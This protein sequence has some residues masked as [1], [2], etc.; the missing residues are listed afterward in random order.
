MISRYY[1][2]TNSKQPS[3]YLRN[4]NRVFRWNQYTIIWVRDT[5]ENHNRFSTEDNTI[6]VPALTRAASRLPR[7]VLDLAYGVGVNP[8]ATDDTLDA[9]NNLI[10][11]VKP[12]WVDIE[13]E[14]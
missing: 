13:H 4:W 3:D 5:I 10:R 9:L 8:P 6:R 14:L 2:L 7:N 12:G 11:R 1:I